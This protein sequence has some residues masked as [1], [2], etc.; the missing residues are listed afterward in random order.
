LNGE[1]IFWSLENFF[2]PRIYCHSKDVAA[3]KSLLKDKILWSH[4]DG[5]TRN[6]IEPITTEARV[7]PANQIFY[8]EKLEWY[9]LAEM[10]SEYRDKLEAVFR[11]LA[12]EGIGGKRSIGCGGY[13]YQPPMDI[14][15]SLSFVSMP[16]QDDFVTLSLYYPT[17][18][19]V[20]AG[21]LGQARFSLIERQ[22]WHTDS[23]GCVNKSRKVR[24]VCEGSHFRWPQISVKSL[25]G[26][27]DPVTCYHYAYPFRIVAAAL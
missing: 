14:P 21:I 23:K 5:R 10:Q 11:L 25:I 3:L 26:L 4:E 18:E 15:E 17:F 16:I 19:N 22:G 24:L 1:K 7:Y 27:D 9:L 12:D 20:Q 2:Y 6:S 13:L 8:S